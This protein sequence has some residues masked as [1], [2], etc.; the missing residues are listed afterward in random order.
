M[1]K[2]CTIIQSATL[3][4]V[5]FFCLTAQVLIAQQ[6]T[7]G[8]N[9]QS[10]FEK[11]KNTR[12]A[13][14][15]SL[16]QSRQSLSAVKSATKSVTKKCYTIQSPC[17]DIDGT[18]TTVVVTGDGTPIYFSASENEN[19]A[20]IGYNSMA[21][22]PGWYIYGGGDDPLFFNE[23]SAET[24][25]L[26]GWVHGINN[27]GTQDEPV[28]L[29]I[30]E[31]TC[32]TFNLCREVVTECGT[33]GGQYNQIGTALGKPLFAKDDL[34]SAIFYDGDDTEGIWMIFSGFDNPPS[35]IAESNADLPPATGWMA[36][37]YAC[38]E[39]AQISVK[40]CGCTPAP[41]NAPG[42]VVIN[43]LSATNCPINLLFPVYGNM[44][45]ITG[46]DNY[47]FSSVYRKPGPYLMNINGIKKP[48]NYTVTVSA[49]NE[50][51]E[52][53][54]KTVTFVVNGQGCK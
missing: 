37:D 2:N 21:D 4:C 5:A 28:S 3:L 46:P 31:A 15:G 54:T 52:V 16:S 50:C 45:L 48:G 7:G 41:V 38:D 17:G 20:Y 36:I 51:G 34:S 9:R 14:K 11:L 32:G 40:S 35:A 10:L 1:S 29:T 53:S 18:F 24:L 47:V 25:P 49:A 43:T 13:Q 19:A 27:C 23:S 39:D 44:G 12:L 33:F 30:T 6:T 22:N 8:I 42:S 26:D